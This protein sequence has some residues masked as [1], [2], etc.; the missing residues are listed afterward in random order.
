[1]A[2]R[3]GEFES[4]RSGRPASRPSGGGGATDPSPAT[5]AAGPATRTSNPRPGFIR[6]SPAYLRAEAKLRGAVADAGL[7][8]ALHEALVGLTECVGDAVEDAMQ[9]RGREAGDTARMA[10]AARGDLKAA[11][12]V[13]HRRLEE[14]RG[15]RAQ[16][17]IAVRELREDMDVELMRLGAQTESLALSVGPS[18]GCFSYFLG[19]CCCLPPDLAA[20]V[21]LAAFEFLH[22]LRSKTLLLWGWLRSCGGTERTGEAD[23]LGDLGSPW[24]RPPRPQRASS[25]NRLLG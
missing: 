22:A 6:E 3:A 8:A 7:P 16:V 19:M 23:D 13:Q 5:E 14:E 1:M 20:G 15:Q 4:V 11:L 12:A 17:Q 10:E 25:E 2:E 21:E 18:Q 24:L 9:A